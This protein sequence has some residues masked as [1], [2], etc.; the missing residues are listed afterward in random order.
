MQGKKI[1]IKDIAKIAGVGVGT[2]SRVLNQDPHVSEETRRKVLQIIEE[3]N[4]TPHYAARSLPKG[5]TYLI[6]IVAPIFTR[7]FFF[8]VIRGISSVLSDTQYDI[9]LFNLANDESRN[10]FFKI[11]P[12]KGKVDGL[13]IISLRLLDKEA[14]ALLNLGIPTVLVDSYHQDFYSISVDN[15]LGGFIATEYLIELGHKEIFHVNEPLE[16]PPF[17]FA[18]GSLR[19][20]GYKKALN[21]YNLPFIENNI[22]Y[23]STTK[24][25]GR[26]AGRLIL[27]RGKIPSAIFAISDLQAIGI[28]DYF[29]EKNVKLP[30]D[31]SIIGYDDLEI[32]QYLD[33]T[34]VSQPIF[35]MGQL[36]ALSLLDILRGKNL[37]TKSVILQPQLK[38][39]GSCK[40]KK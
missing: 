16:N 37:E 14:K 11:L 10:R 7:P 24:E 38:I 18:V 1:T 21:L 23:T 35:Q 34:T 32:A 40:P 28:L 8:E 20:E 33:L 17:G 29:K 31:F 3:L 9:V 19:L 5:K 4:Y 36:S 2:I 30:E 15:V 39:R 25:G 13:I 12:I 27:E 6:G 26:K 22:I